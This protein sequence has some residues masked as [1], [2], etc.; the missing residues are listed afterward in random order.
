[1]T[2][3]RRQPDGLPAPALRRVRRQGRSGTWNSDLSV[4]ELAAI[5]SAGFTPAG[6]VMGCAVYCIPWPGIAACATSGATRST[7]IELGPYGR[8]LD[9]ARRLALRRMTWEAAELGGHGVVGVR[10]QVRPFDQAPD[11]VEFS[12]IGT[13]VRRD[14][15]AP[16]AAPFLSALDGQGL[17]KLLRAGL[18][19][20]G[21][22][23]GVAAVH[24][25]TSE[26]AELQMSRGD[27]EVQDFS[28]AATGVRSLAMRR[29]TQAALAVHADG[30]PGIK[31]CRMARSMSF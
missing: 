30:L 20:C 4:P 24:V 23:M 11:A 29:L 6:Q 31:T 7:A 18:V 8:A 28:R 1:M 14:G 9:E 19:P 21:M 15:A 16:L 26:R 13:A 22:A 27:A 2:G 5:R 3:S 12:A 10:L 25:H 17:A